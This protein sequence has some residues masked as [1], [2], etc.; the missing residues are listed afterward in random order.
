MTQTVY[1]LIPMRDEDDLELSYYSS[2]REAQEDGERYY[3]G[4]YLIEILEIDEDGETVSCH[5]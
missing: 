5:I 2:Y 4:G 1:N 3:P